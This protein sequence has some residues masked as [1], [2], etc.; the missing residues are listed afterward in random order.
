MKGNAD[1]V[2]QRRF[3]C[4]LQLANEFSRIGC[5]RSALHACYVSGTARMMNVDHAIRINQKIATGELY[6]SN[7]GYSQTSRLCLEHHYVIFAL[8]YIRG[9]A[10]HEVTPDSVSLRQ[11]ED[12]VPNDQICRWK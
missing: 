4:A 5:S 3:E 11:S 9:N 7:P 1:G 2:C 6:H 12:S 8:V 10:A